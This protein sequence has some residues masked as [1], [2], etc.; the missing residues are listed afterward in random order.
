[1]LFVEDIEAETEGIA[2]RGIAVDW[3]HHYQLERPDGTLVEWDLT[4]LGDQELGTVVPILVSDR[5]PREYR[6]NVDE[7]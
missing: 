7:E 6:V 5:T 4:V 2:D 1:M 3:L